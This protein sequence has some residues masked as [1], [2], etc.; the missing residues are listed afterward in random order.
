MCV[1]MRGKAL[2]S[3]GILTGGGPQ[4]GRAVRGPRVANLGGR[5]D[6]TRCDLSPAI[7]S[8]INRGRIYTHPDSHCAPCGDK[9]VAISECEEGAG[10]G[11][12]SLKPEWDVSMLYGLLHTTVRW[13]EFESFTEQPPPLGTAVK[14]KVSPQTHIQILA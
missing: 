14:V 5:R 8:S 9:D 6:G 4:E 1:R 12:H 3:R 11:L 10:S 2:S 13:G 7:W